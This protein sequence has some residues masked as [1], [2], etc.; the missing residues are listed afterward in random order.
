MTNDSEIDS[1]L[2][3][4]HRTYVNGSENGSDTI[5]GKTKLKQVIMHLSN[6]DDIAAENVIQHLLK[7]WHEVN[8]ND[9]KHIDHSPN[10]KNKH[11][12]NNNK[13]YTATAESP[14]LDELLAAGIHN[15]AEYV[16]NT[17]NKTVK[18]DDSLV[19][20]VFYAGCSTWTFDPINLG[21]AA[22]TS[23]GKTYT[24]IQVLQYFPKKISS[25]LAQCHLK[26]L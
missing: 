12:N 20:A 1:R 9:D 2:D 5:T 4:I 10:D 3:T 6:C 11:D 22:P 17:I 26:S 13:Q 21:I 25:T 16:I 18:L 24:V 8:A 7:I 23:E 15:P 19:R 14:L